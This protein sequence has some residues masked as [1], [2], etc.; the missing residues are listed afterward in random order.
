MNSAA[1]V[2]NDFSIKGQFK[3]TDDFCEYYADRLGSVLSFLEENDFEIIKDKNTYSRQLTEDMTLG[4]L[5]QQGGNPVVSAFMGMIIKLTYDEPWW[6]DDPMTDPET[7]YDYPD[8]SD[9]P[10]CIT[11]AIARRKPILSFVWNE[12]DPD[13]LYGF[14]ENGISDNLFNVFSSISFLRILLLV[15]RKKLGYVIERYPFFDNK[16]SLR[17]VMVCEKEMGF[18]DEADLTDKDLEKVLESLQNVITDKSSGTKSRFW[19]DLGGGLNE[20]R[21]TVSAGREFRWYFTWGKTMRLLNGCI[22]KSQKP[23]QNVLDKARRLAKEYY[24]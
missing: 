5:L 19:D 9:E 10:N 14:S 1:V 3:D 13:F 2:L 23:P 20:Y 11:E 15:D 24:D 4:Q 7:E 8:K 6:N 17:K 21:L 18:V 16:G 12:Q 22:K